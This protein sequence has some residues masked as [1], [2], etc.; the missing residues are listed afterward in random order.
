M[1]TGYFSGT[2]DSYY[3][4]NT[5]IIRK[6]F[7][8]A[9]DNVW[10]NGGGD[11]SYRLANAGYQ[12]ILALATHLYFDHPYEPDPAERGY[13]WATRYTDTRKAFGFIPDNIYANA[14]VKRNGERLTK[15]EI[16]GENT[17]YE[18]TKPENIIAVFGQKANNDM[19][20]GSQE[21]DEF[22]D[23]EKVEYMF[24]TDGDLM[25]GAH[26]DNETDS[27]TENETDSQAENETDSQ[28]ENETDSQTEAE[29]DSQT[30]TVQPTRKRR[31]TETSE[32]STETYDVTD[33]RPTQDERMAADDFYT[34]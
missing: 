13:Y 16:C 5:F 32:I 11:R 33:Y 3:K 34:E 21:T 30:E 28:T 6:A 12:V 24:E 17:C 29:T 8:S 9:W 4:K 14:D 10:E 1:A 31:R 2:S 25:T 26:T 15:S 19:C 20:V 22:I 23:D 7:T 27:Q 18:L